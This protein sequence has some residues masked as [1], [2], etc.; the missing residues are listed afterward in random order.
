[1]KFSRFTQFIVAFASATSISAFPLLPLYKRELGGVSDP[2]TS[3]A[4]VLCRT[5]PL[6]PRSCYAQVPTQQAHAPTKF[7]SSM[8]AI[9]SKR[10][11][12]ITRARF[13][14]TAR[15]S[16]AILARSIATT[17][18]RALQG[19]PLAQSTTNMKTKRI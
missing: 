17:F 5:D 2:L 16:S 11:S 19:V 3:F 4:Y 7:M 8:Y 15:T 12:I 14:Q 9:N 18:A 6:S 13:P 10:L 1:M